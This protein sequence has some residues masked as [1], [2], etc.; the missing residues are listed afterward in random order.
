MSLAAAAP[1]AECLAGQ[2]VGRALRIV[3]FSHAADLRQRLLELGFT[4]GTECKVLRYAPLGDPM[5]VLVRGYTLSM[6]STEA[7][8]V[9]VEVAQ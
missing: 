3:G 6:R 1:V 8:G 5:Q 4:I 2:P 7:E 9:L